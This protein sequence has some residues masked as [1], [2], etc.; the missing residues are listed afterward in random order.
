MAAFFEN[1]GLDKLNLALESAGTDK[2]LTVDILWV[3]SNIA[4]ES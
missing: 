4:C 3:L 2:Y 1:N